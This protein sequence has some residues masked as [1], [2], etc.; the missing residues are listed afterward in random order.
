MAAS[1][2]RLF[3]SRTGNLYGYPV[4]ANTRLFGRTL[5][6]VNAAGN[7]LRPQDS[8]AVA[9]V[10]WAEGRADNT[11]GA[12]GDQI[13]RACKDVLEFAFD[14]APTAAHIG[15]TVYAVDDDTVSRSH[16]TN[17]RLRVGVIDGIEGSLVFI[18]FV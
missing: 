7:A 15:A 14:T 11:G 2:D 1:A 17:T 9:I 16:E 3:R 6:A 4:A 18:R 12:A 13:V 5:V 8:G 10:G